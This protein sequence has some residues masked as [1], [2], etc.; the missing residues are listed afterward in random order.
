MDIQEERESFEQFCIDTFLMCPASGCFKREQDDVEFY[1]DVD[2]HRLW[3][4]WQLKAKAQATPE[5][6]VLVEKSKVHTW[7]QDDNEPENFCNFESDLDCL[8]DFLDDDDIITVNIHES[9]HLGTR[10][11]F[12]VWKSNSPTDIQS[13][14]ILVD[15]RAEAEEIVTANKAMFKT[16]KQSHD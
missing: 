14:F 8:G 13:K 15:S 4:L 9:V 6:F 7:Y 2:T 1:E 10:K 5:G 11:V 12:G 3:H 16:Q